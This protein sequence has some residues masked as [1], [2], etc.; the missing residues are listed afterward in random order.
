MSH[1]GKAVTVLALLTLVVGAGLLGLY[2]VSRLLSAP[3]KGFSGPE[4][5]VDIP[6]GTSI[7]QIGRVLH[8]AGVVSH[9]RLFAWFVRLSYPTSSMKAGEYRFDRA[10]SLRDVAA[11]LAKGEV[12]FIKVTV[13]EGFSRTDIVDLLV[14]SGIG[15]NEGLLTETRDTK[16]IAHLDN[17]ASDLEGYLFPDTYFFSRRV[18][19]KEVAE[20]MVSR[21]LG[22]WTEE[23]QKKARELNMTP[24][25]VLTLA[26]LIEKETALPTERQLVSA[27]FHN[28]LKKNIALGSDPTVIYSVKLVKD[29]D[30]VINQSDLKLDSPYNTYLYYGLPPGPIASPGLASIDAA[31]D[32]AEVDYLYFVSRNDGSHLFTVDYREHQRGVQQYQR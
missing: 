31:L 22:I 4:V 20:R 6:K 24:R 15:T 26:S 1:R 16:T 17:R 27:V 5:F 8:R 11:K 9:P 30:G 12:Y 14:R 29:Y 19:E 25:E 32:P 3:Y 21:F 7:P 2:Q 10:S 13:P 23:R 28:R 18:S